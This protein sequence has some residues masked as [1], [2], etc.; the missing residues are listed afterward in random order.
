MLDALD[1]IRPLLPIQLR[2]LLQIPR[3]QLLSIK[4][5]AAERRQLKLEE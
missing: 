4:E 5:R 1:G 2:V 3:A